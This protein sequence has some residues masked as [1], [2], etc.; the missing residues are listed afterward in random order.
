MPRHP[1]VPVETLRAI[2]VPR[3]YVP[4]PAAQ[5]DMP[6]PPTPVVSPEH[7]VVVHDDDGDDDQLGGD[8]FG[9]FDFGGAE[10]PP[11]PHQRGT[12][13]AVRRYDASGQ[14][15]VLLLQS[16]HSASHTSRPPSY[17]MPPMT[18][19]HLPPILMTYHYTQGG[20]CIR[21]IFLRI[22]HMASSTLPC[23]LS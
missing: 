21:G 23:V 4:S 22:R 11:Q 10:Q 19:Y 2:G 8:N 3:G 7:D 16:S 14:S 15:H 12:S 1:P 6:L 17:D 5:P 20:L 13:L 9:G 18:A